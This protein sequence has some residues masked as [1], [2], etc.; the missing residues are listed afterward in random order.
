[1]AVGY[2]LNA[3]LS[4]NRWPLFIPRMKCGWCG[5]KRIDVRP[6]WKEAPK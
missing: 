5:G 4:R 6:N 3:K 1:M 2:C